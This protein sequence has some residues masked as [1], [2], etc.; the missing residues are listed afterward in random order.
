MSPVLGSRKQ[1]RHKRN[2]TFSCSA[3]SLQ[4]CPTLCD[5]VVCSPPGSSAHAILQARILEPVAISSSH[6]CSY[7]NAKVWFLK[8]VPFPYRIRKQ[9]LSTA[10]WLPQEPRHCGKSGIGAGWVSCRHTKNGITLLMLFAL[11]IL[12]KIRTHHYNMELYSCQLFNTM[13][14]LFMKAIVSWICV[15]G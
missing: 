6:T 14:S 5:P 10:E 15:T 3:K 11:L 13:K 7:L 9:I 2:I 4:L 1:N 12:F 8:P